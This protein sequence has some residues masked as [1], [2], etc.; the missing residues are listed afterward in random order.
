MVEFRVPAGLGEGVK[1]NPG[2]VHGYA[3]SN[4]C[5]QNR[6]IVRELSLFR[7][8]KMPYLMKELT[9][10]SLSEIPAGFAAGTQEIQRN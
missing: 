10:V 3:F 1:P 8:S 9:L 5:R 4:I 6:D 2:G 7:P